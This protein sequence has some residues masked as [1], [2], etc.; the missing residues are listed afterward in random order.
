[1]ATHN[2]IGGLFIET[3]RPDEAEKAQQRAGGLLQEIMKD[4]PAQAPQRTWL[5][6]HYQN[7]GKLLVAT[8]QLKN[9][10]REYQK[11]LEIL[12]Q[13][14]RDCPNIAEYKNDLAT[15]F[16][17]LGNMFVQSK[18]FREAQAS[19]TKAR[20]IMLALVGEFPTVDKYHSNLGTAFH[21]FAT[22]AFD[23]GKTQEACTL[24]NQAI[25]HHQKALALNP[26]SA[27]A[28]KT[29]RDS[30]TILIA[31]A[32]QRGDH[33]EAARTCRILG[34]L[35]PDSFEDHK[36]AVTFLGRSID[37]AEK[38]GRLWP[39]CRNPLTHIYAQL[40]KDLLEKMEK[41][42]PGPYSW[43]NEMAWFLATSPAHR[44]RNPTRAVA[45]AQKAVKNQPHN[46]V[47]KNTLGVALYRNAQYKEAVVALKESM[48]LK[49]DGDICDWFFLAMAYWNLKEENMARAYYAKGLEWMKKNPLDDETR[50]FY[51]EV[52]Q[53]IPRV[54]SL[55]FSQD[56][57]NL[58]RI[59]LARD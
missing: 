31:A 41:L 14:P 33:L 22:L 35:M 58:L 34:R 54:D 17:L 24:E 1:A 32:I 53:M 23:Q 20:D 55:T 36:R 59:A 47:Y 4:L 43:E 30:Y 6:N 52:T 28:K 51:D 45:M 25:G 38:D 2:L 18:D 8:H 26:Q 49:N 37:L 16:N 19:Y 44:F 15:Q 46:G 57:K 29:L 42:N 27:S 13:L 50:R 10:R 11:A 5:A 39:I 56:W 21:Q 9:A 7:R 40:V 48:V 12:A 3:H